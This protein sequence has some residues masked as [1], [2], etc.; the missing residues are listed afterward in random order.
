MATTPEHTPNRM[1]L[2]STVILDR[3]TVFQIFVEKFASS[4][5][6]FWVTVLLTSKV[7]ALSSYNTLRELLLEASVLLFYSTIKSI[8]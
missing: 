8:S 4:L 1:I 3:R 6:S 7:T 2:I 5:F